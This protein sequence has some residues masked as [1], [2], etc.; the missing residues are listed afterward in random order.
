MDQSAPTANAIE[1]MNLPEGKVT[2]SMPSSLCP[3]SMQEFE[4]WLQLILRR[5]HRTQGDPV[6]PIVETPKR[7]EQ[8]AQ[9][10]APKTAAPQGD[11]TQKPGPVG[12]QGL[13]PSVYP[14]APPQG[15]SS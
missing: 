11:E 9:T 8:V 14:V 15:S 12:A 6:R 2:L 5:M 4:V 3:E 7:I 1:L 13:D 10:P